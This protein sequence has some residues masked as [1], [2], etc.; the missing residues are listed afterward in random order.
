MAAEERA[1]ADACE[2]ETRVTASAPPAASTISLSSRRWTITAEDEI[3]LIP[4]VIGLPHLLPLNPKQTWPITPE[5]MRVIEKEAAA[6]NPSAL[7]VLGTTRICC[8]LRCLSQ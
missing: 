7:C 3:L 5:R 8:V 2:L 4:A 6:R 1:K